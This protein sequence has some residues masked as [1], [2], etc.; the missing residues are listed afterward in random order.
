MITWAASPGSSDFT[1][2]GESQVHS[3]QTTGG[4]EYEAGYTGKV[5]VC[6]SNLGKRLLPRGVEPLQAREILKDS[7]VKLLVKIPREESSLSCSSCLL[8]PASLHSLAL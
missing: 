7:L 5:L 4:K 8:A 6:K 2:P 3:L 1:C